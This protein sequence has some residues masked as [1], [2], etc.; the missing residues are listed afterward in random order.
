VRLAREVEKEG[1]GRR[2]RKI[3]K[4]RR[5]RK[6]NQMKVLLRERRG[7]I[8]GKKGDFNH[9]EIKSSIRRGG[10][11]TILVFKKLGGRGI[12]RKKKT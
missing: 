10:G 5:R 12:S 11:H 2:A 8:L 6:K 4:I 3:P 9:H 7:W 1:E